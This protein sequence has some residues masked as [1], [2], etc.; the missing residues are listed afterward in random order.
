MRA[1]TQSDISDEAEYEDA[2]KAFIEGTSDG[3][4]PLTDLDSKE[5]H[6]AATDGFV[7]VIFGVVWHP[8]NY[9]RRPSLQPMLS[10]QASTHPNPRA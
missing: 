7:N 4:I 9:H 5:I 2:P 3:P 10:S 6:L 8:A 1:T